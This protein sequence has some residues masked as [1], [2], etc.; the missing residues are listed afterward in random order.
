MNL[1]FIRKF[2]LIL[3]LYD[4]EFIMVSYEKLHFKRQN[5]S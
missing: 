5:E 3:L 4:I 2:V 1:T